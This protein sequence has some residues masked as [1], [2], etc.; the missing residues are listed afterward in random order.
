MV[1]RRIEVKQRAAL[2]RTVSLKGVALQSVWHPLPGLLGTVRIQLDAV[3]KHRGAARHRC[4]GD[5]VADA[6]I[7]RSAGVPGKPQE[8]SNPLGLENRK[9]VEPHFSL[10]NKSHLCLVSARGGATTS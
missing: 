6:R 1:V 9:R 3:P 2:N 8:G 4:K 10:R 5:S 7:Q